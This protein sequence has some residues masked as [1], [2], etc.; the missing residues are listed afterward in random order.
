M[1]VGY[2]TY[3]LSAPMKE[4][5][6][7]SVLVAFAEVVDE[8]LLDGL[9]VGHE[10]V[11]DGVAADEPKYSMGAAMGLGVEVAKMFGNGARPEEK[12]VPAG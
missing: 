7:Q 9:V 1:S 3:R 11:T 12:L 8:H 10:H 2:H 6:I 5:D 4:R